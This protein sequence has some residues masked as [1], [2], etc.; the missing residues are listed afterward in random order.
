MTIT[1]GEKVDMIKS[2]CADTRTCD[3]N[4]VIK[5]QLLENSESHISDVRD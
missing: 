3:W 2:S 1:T 4:K 5:D